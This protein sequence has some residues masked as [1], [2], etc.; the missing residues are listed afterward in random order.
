MSA[1]QTIRDTFKHP[2]VLAVCCA[3]VVSV[4]YWQIRTDW[5]ESKQLIQGR[6]LFANSSSGILAWKQPI[7]PAQFAQ[8][9]CGACH[10]EDL[11]Q[12]PRLSHG[13]QLI[14]KFNCIGCHQL[15]DIDRPTML[16]PD[17]TNVGTKVSREWIYKWLKDPRTV[18]DADGNVKVDGVDLEPRM[19]KF[20]LSDIELRALSAYLSVQRVKKI[21]PSKIAVAIAK[22]GDAADRGQTRYNQIFCV[23][24]HAI[25]VERG[26]ETK[27]IGGDIGPELTKVGSKVRPEW[28]V[29]WLRDPQGYIEHT[30]MPRYQWS[31]KDLY[32]VTQYILTKLTDSDLLKNVP[33]LGPP[34]DS[35]VQ[36]GRGLFIEKGC[37]ECHV[38]QGVKPKP[39]F[40][41]DLSALG[42]AAGPYSVEI[43]SP[44]KRS[45]GFHFLKKDVERLDISESIVP[46]SMI[47]YLQT[48][49]T[50]PAS[51][52]PETHMPQFHLGQSDLDDLTTALLSMSGPPIASSSHD[53][54]IVE[55][56]H[57]EFHPDGEAGQL[58]QQY[59]CYVCHRFN[60]YG[61]TLAPD[62]SY[63]GSRS[64]RDW[65]IQFLRN[66]QTLRPT[67]TVRMPVFSM[68]EQDAT[69][70]ADFLLA[71]LRKPEVNPT[72][73]G[74]EAFTPQMADAGKQLF[75]VK[76]QCQSCHTI[77]S[78]GGYVGPSLNNVGNWM[79]PAWIEAWL[80]NP[81]ALIPDAIEPRHSFNDDEV[82]NL[83]AYLLTL[84]QAP[85]APSSASISTGGGQP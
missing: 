61:G 14:T 40:A 36:L 79:T 19:P 9:S 76:Y 11:A 83:T 81:Q 85:A 65:L 64:R 80:R 37:A 55:R 75:E 29:A 41:P 39:E 23:T 44:R 35:E 74:D 8:A 1:K 51:I 43:R 84:R 31:D 17:L 60:G 30:K 10:R 33:E 63:E 82:K 54:V 57:T 2:Y 46:R 52:T 66:P 78:S 67:L 22:T 49:I 47:A 70:L 4:I 72:A 68:S 69:T 26:G 34:A 21:E 32:D 7:V 53:Q 18:T 3:F 12:T 13:R 20:Q 28:L 42:M 58:Y 59:R 38:I 71:N 73:I 5:L 48:K 50:D 27:L 24:C 15:Q 62:L 25:A 45:V 6:V 56:R 16:G 77:G